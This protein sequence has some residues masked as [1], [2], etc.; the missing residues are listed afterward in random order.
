MATATA[1]PFSAEI[2]QLPLPKHTRTDNKKTENSK[3][4]K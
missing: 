3:T 2:Q 4:N 1:Q